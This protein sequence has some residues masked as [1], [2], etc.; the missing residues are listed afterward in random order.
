MCLGLWI[1]SFT[2]VMPTFFD[3]GGHRYDEKT[4]M[5]VWNRVADFSYTIFCQTIGLIL[6]I[7]LTAVCYVKIFLFVRAQKKKVCE[8]KH[9]KSMAH[10]NPQIH[11]FKK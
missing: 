5:C 7:I 2:I 8:R 10:N 9:E 3:W 11:S 4:E 6:P 1:L